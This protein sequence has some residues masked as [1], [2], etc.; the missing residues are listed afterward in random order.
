MTDLGEEFGFGR[1]R[2]LRFAL[3]VAQL[4][5]GG[6]KRELGGAAADRVQSV[7]QDERQRRSAVPRHR[8]QPG[9]DRNRVAAARHDRQRLRA[10]TF[11]EC[12]GTAL[13]EQRIQPAGGFERREIVVAGRFEEMTIGVEQRIVPVYQ[14]ADRKTVEQ[15][16][17]DAGGRRHHGGDRF[18]RN[19]ALGFIRTRRLLGRGQRGR[20]F[21]GLVR[22]LR[23]FGQRAFDIRR[24]GGGRLR[25]AAQARVQFLRQFA[26][27]PTL[28]RTE[29]RRFRFRSRR[30]TE[31]HH[32]GGGR[33]DIE[34]RALGP[35]CR[36]GGCGA[37]RRRRRGV[38][39]VRRR[40]EAD[41]PF[42]ARARQLVDAGDVAA[43]A[44]TAI[45]AKAA[46]A[47]EHR[48]ARQLDRQPVAGF[49]HRPGNDDAAPGLVARHRARDLIVGIEFQLGRDLAPGA[50]ERRR[51]FRPDQR[52]EFIGA[53]DEAAV[54]IHLP[55]EPQ[56]VTPFDDRL[57]GRS[58]L[59]RW[60]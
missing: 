34:R 14:H 38:I 11:R 17:I 16:W 7:G 54:G 57:G 10:G 36:F 2:L 5:L 8:E 48:Q 23:R 6:G 58:G 25:R 28:H 22:R 50:A 32:I 4:G 42:A 13:D 35:R 52:D 37:L 21:G 53:D 59:R 45:A 27:R 31:R 20:G 40:H 24:G 46:V 33:R 39:G 56:R 12:I 44:K 1:R 51:G 29:R 43:D 41:R 9:V 55:D 19:R 49:I 60:R 26:E 18:C 30:L 15:R 3:G 47:I